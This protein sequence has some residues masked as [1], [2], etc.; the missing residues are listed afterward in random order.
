MGAESSWLLDRTWV[1]IGRLAL[2][3][4]LGAGVYLGSLWLLG[5]RLRDFVKR[6]S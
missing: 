4:V 2:L 1:R 6:V 5:I 3:V